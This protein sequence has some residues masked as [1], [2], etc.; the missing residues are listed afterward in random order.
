MNDIMSLKE[1]GFTYSV[2][3]LFCVYFNKESF[4]TTSPG[5]KKAEEDKEYFSNMFRDYG[6]FSEELF[7]FFY[8]LGNNISF[9]TRYYFEPYKREFLSG[10]YDLSVIRGA[11]NDY[12]QVVTN[13][14]QYYFKDFIIWSN[15]IFY[16]IFH[17]YI[18][19][20]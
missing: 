2:L 19:Q 4:Y 5:Y 20:N 14:L 7:P 6:S 18:D 8:R 10:K 12:D 3:F 17:I 9:M 15:R 1:P 16:C 13:F 11:L